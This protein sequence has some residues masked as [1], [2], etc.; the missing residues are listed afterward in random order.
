MSPHYS[1]LD[2]FQNFETVYSYAYR[3]F[4]CIFH[5]KYFYIKS[6]EVTKARQFSNETGSEYIGKGVSKYSNFAIQKTKKFSQCYCG[7]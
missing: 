2:I 5:T 7:S 4:V 1:F 3:Q 6:G